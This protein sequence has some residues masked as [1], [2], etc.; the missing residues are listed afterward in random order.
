MTRVA[1]GHDRHLVP[2]RRLPQ[3]PGV[4]ALLRYQPA[5]TAV[6]ASAQ[7]SGAGDVLAVLVLV[8]L[9][10]PEGVGGNT[11]PSAAWYHDAA[12]A[13]WQWC[14]AYGSS[15]DRAVRQLLL[16]RSPR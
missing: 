4:R 13:R 15:R 8:L 14:L 1:N 5:E 12:F 11:T 2:Y 3:S 16:R 7:I 9:A 10:A 6:G